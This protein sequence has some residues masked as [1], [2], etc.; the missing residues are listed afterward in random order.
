MSEADVD[1]SGGKPS[2]ALIPYRRQLF[3][4]EE[5]LVMRYA[6]SLGNYVTV[7]RI[8]YEAMARFMAIPPVLPTGGFP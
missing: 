2:Y 8:M 4:F 5:S 1:G 3:T 7:D 6:N